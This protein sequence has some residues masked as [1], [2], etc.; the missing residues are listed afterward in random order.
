MTA[1]I[2]S[3]IKEITLNAATYSGVGIT[4]T[5][6]NFFFGNNGTGKSTIAK[7]IKA[8]DGITWLP[9]KTEA[10]Y[11]VLVFDQDFISANIQSYG[12]LPGVFTM[13]E[14]NIGVQNQIEE[15]SKA[16][17][18]F[19]EQYGKFSIEKG[20]KE[21]EETS[22]LTTFQNSCWDKAKLLRE[23]F[24]ATQT[25][26]KRKQQFAE[27]VLGIKTPQEHNLDDLKR[28]YEVAFD[29]NSRVYDEFTTIS[30][31][32]ALDSHPGDDILGKKIVSSGD[33]PFASFIKALNATDWVR[34]GH[35]QFTKDSDGKCPYCQ[36]PIP[37]DFENQIAACFDEHYQQDIQKLKEFYES[38]KQ[39]ANNLFLS[40]QNTPQDIYPKVNIDPLRD[41]QALLKKTIE[42]NLQKITNKI[43]EPANA[44]TLEETTSLLQEINTLIFEFNKSIIEN[45][46]VV[47]AKQQKQAECKTKAW[48]LIAYTLKDEVSSYKTSNRNL[49]NEISD[50][51]TKMT[52]CRNKSLTL[53]NEIINLNRQVVNTKAT[54][55]SINSLLRDSGFQGFS[56]REKTGLQNVYEVIRP[57]G[58]I[59]ENLSEGERNFI[60][61]LYFYHLIKGSDSADGGLKDKVVVIDD[62][63]SSMD[64]NSLFIVSA[65]TREMI[66]ICHNNADYMNIS[67][68]GDF[69]KQIFILTHNAYFHREIT[70]NQVT[71]YICVSFFLI[72]KVDNISSV[73]LCKRQNVQIP[74]EN[75]NYNPVQNSYAALWDEY[76]ELATTIPLLNV[77]RRILEYYFLQLCGYDGTDI[78]QRILKDNKDKFVTTDVEGKEDYT[79]YHVASAMLSYISTTS[80]DIND[81]LNYVDGGM[82]V[83][84]CK[85]TF[86]MIFELMNQEQHYKMMMGTK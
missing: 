15:K 66:E 29:P 17:K 58:A 51:T 80:T 4:P 11:T 62:P 12:N 8:N 6:I 19:D 14:E 64:S 61:F 81:G 37:D 53:N 71:R 36:Q 54:I 73:K 9:G 23:G 26:K 21:N 7:R 33:T 16:K 60:A 82:D 68:Q 39:L 47:N 78:R 3:A 85:S 76:K 13:N 57:N 28:L 48:E 74:T 55:D 2:P 42:A 25:G 46:S 75:E 52:N 65:L 72:N 63:V 84:E 50:L 77:I 59:A 35:E 10:D 27:A 34:Q 5:L 18:E 41:K 20:K 38:Y 86:K 31:T 1:K 22:L 24:D 69:I 79:Q 56:I 32:S 67:S 43:A 30:N 70:Y 49:R 45:N 40:L 83:K 44:V